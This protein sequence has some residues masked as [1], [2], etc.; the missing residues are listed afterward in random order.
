MLGRQ[1]RWRTESLGR[2]KICLVLEKLVVVV[3]RRVVFV[4][5]LRL[6]MD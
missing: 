2:R 3:V 6:V 4:Q 1:A 5:W